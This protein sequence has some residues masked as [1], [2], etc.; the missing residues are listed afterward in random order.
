[1]ELF[2]ASRSNRNCRIARRIGLSEHS[3]GLSVLNSMLKKWPTFCRE[4]CH[5]KTDIK[6]LLGNCVGFGVPLIGPI[7][8]QLLNFV[9]AFVCLKVRLVTTDNFVLLRHFLMM[10]KQIST[11]NRKEEWHENSAHP[12]TSVKYRVG[13]VHAVL[14]SSAFWF[15][16][17]HWRPWRG[18][19]K[20]QHLSASEEQKR[21]LPLSASFPYVP[22]MCTRKEKVPGVHRFK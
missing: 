20:P 15:L 17:P 14:V 1:M 5:F 19:T 13:D 6:L 21:K 12:G 10:W 18:H 11:G 2:L 4:S 7:C 9:A 16:P 22:W 3:Y 8:A